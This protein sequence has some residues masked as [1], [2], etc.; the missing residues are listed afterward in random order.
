MY[1]KIVKGI[2]GFYYVYV[3]GAGIYECKAKGIF[4]NQKQKPL[5]GDQVE[6]TIL[7]ERAHTGNI[8]RILPRT[9]EL[10]RPAVANIDQALVIFAV[11]KPD[12]NYN[13]LDRF[14]CRMEQ[15][16]VPVI[17]CFHKADLASEEEK[18]ELVKIYQP[19][20]YPV[21]F[22]SIHQEE[23]IEELRN[24]LKGKTT[25][26]AGPS[27]VGKSSLINC[28]LGESRME[29]GQ[30]STK[31][32]RGKHTTRHSEI[33]ALGDETYIMETPGFSSLDV[34]DVEK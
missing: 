12:P 28:L 18:I 10:V 11:K 30:I 25:T 32:A 5:I 23:S 17:I 26:V 8:E 15:Q 20:G 29:T 19:A 9:R 1:G 14:L 33:L 27:G 6:I 24:L 22:T 21:H 4:R 13:L 31:I 7:D 3:E 16:E 2:A 34:P